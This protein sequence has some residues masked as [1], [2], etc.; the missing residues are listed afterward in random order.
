[1]QRISFILI[2]ALG[3]ASVLMACKSSKTSTDSG[4]DN[5]EN[6]EKIS[7]DV[8]DEGPY[9]G[10]QEPVSRLI[11]N[12]DE[13]QTFYKK[14]GSN[15][16]P[17]PEAPEVNFEENALIVS[18]MGMRTSG[19]HKVEINSMVKEGK[20]IKVSLTYVAPGDNCMVTE[21]L[22]QPY[23]FALVSNQNVSAAEF[24]VVERTDNCNQ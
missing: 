23:I 2:I 14:F 12:N 8:L 11:T 9:C 18:L 13:W 16:F 24:E 6:A 5:G 1:M 22:T 15:R 4:T 3:L 21:A 19:G 10:I 20:T 17:S 7:W